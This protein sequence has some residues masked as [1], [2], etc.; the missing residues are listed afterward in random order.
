[1]RL[2]LLADN[3]VGEKIALFLMEN[4][5]NDLVLIVTTKINDIYREANAK[6]FTVCVFD[7]ENNILDRLAGDFDLGIL[8]WWP[9]IIKSSLIDTPRL[10]FLNTHPSLLPHNRGKHYNFWALV[11]QA[12]FGVTIHKV[13]SGVDTGDIVAQATIDY[14]WCDTGQTLYYKAQSAM[15]DLFCKTYPVLR[16]GQY[17]SNPQN[18][19][20]GSFHR[21]VEIE[22]ASMINLDA[23]YRGRELLNLLRART[24]EGYPG[25]WFK[26]GGERYEISVKIRKVN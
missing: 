17:D 3:V 18:K 1:M 6:G 20:L 7:S 14:D 15:F 10:G 22:D 8:A 19:C 9:K 25:C 21:A 23:N 4:Y 24:F 13:D 16:K 12:P 2:V 11:E 26:D 5:P